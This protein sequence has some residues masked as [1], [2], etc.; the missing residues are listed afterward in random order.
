MVRGTS[1]QG[2]LLAEKVATSEPTGTHS[3]SSDE[4]LRFRRNGTVMRRVSSRYPI[5]LLVTGK[6]N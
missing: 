4:G 2:M 5:V 1:P 3:L 6:P